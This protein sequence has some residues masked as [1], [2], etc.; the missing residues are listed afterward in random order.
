MPADAAIALESR[1]VGVNRTRV[2]LMV[3]GGVVVLAAALRFIDLGSQSFWFDES[4]TATIIRRP[5][6]GVLH[7][8]PS[9]ESTPP[10][11]YV[12]VWGWSKL[13]GSSEAGLRS[14]SAL[15]GTAT[16]PVAWLATRRLASGR[17]AAIAAAL[18]A[19]EPTLVW[20]SQETR[21]Y[22]LMVFLGALSFLFFLQA[23]ESA[24]SSALTAWA[25][26]SALALATH[27][28]AAFL[29]AAEAL[30]LGLAV[31]R[32]RRR[33]YVAAG[34][35]IVVVG[36]TLLPLAI[37]QTDTGRSAWIAGIP[38]DS[39]LAAVFRELFTAGTSRIAKL[40]PLPVGPWGVI[41]YALVLTGIWMI[42]V[43]GGRAERKPALLCAAIGAAAVLVPLLLWL[44]RLDF[45]LD[46]NLLAAWVPL[47]IALSIGFGARRAGRAG[48]AAAIALCAMA[49]VVDAEVYTSPSLQRGDWRDLARVLGPPTETRILLITPSYDATTLSVYGHPTIP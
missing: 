12:L 1:A 43:L 19:V 5:L 29:I 14:F 41:G 2:D 15:V 10:L 4:A 16:V 49:V 26:S 24:T 33:A 39:R 42:V 28:F 40:A 21:A 7:A 38:F 37:A 34:C 20:Y 46:R 13:F 45:F 30:A 23:R 18:I 35:G 22:A 11:Y 17:V 48:I 27:Y 3:L 25:I 32:H 44:A 36:V 8:L 9:G 6:S 31:P 47:L